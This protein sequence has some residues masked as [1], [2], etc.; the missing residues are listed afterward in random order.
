M[1]TVTLSSGGTLRQGDTLPILAAQLFE[2]DGTAAV[3]TGRTCTVTMRNQL[4]KVAVVSA[5][6][7]TVVNALTGLVSYAWQ[8]ADTAAAG[9]FEAEFRVTTTSGGALESYPNAVFIPITI[10]PAI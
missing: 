6:A 3:L 5:A 4:N 2:A 8:S 7:C 10:L 9:N 1:S